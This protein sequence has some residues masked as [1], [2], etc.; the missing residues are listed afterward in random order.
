MYHSLES[1]R[2]NILFD[3]GCKTSLNDLFT[4][5]FE[6][7]LTVTVENSSLGCKTF[8]ELLLKI[9]S[10]PPQ[11]YQMTSGDLYNIYKI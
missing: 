8:R 2:F 4:S 5:R 1:D 6:L 7:V 10:V 9:L 3:P 11:S